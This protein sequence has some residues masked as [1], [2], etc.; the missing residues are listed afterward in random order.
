MKYF[1]LDL[2]FRDNTGLK[3]CRTTGFS[4]Q[5]LTL[6][7]NDLS[8]FQDEIQQIEKLSDLSVSQKTWLLFLSKETV[9]EITYHF[10]IIVSLSFLIPGQG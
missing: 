5:I 2:R 1:S 6:T 9:E 10:I 8:N 3:I 4:S 7:P